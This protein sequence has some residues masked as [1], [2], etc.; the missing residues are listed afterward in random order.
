M[1][2]SRPQVKAMDVTG[3]EVVRLHG[4]DDRKMFDYC[5]PVFIGIFLFVF[6]FITSG[7]LLVTEHTGGTM[8]RFLTT[9]I[10]GV[11]VLAGYAGAFG[12]LSLV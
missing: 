2:S 3:V 6:T 11:Q 7:M 1:A 12:A 5:G 10:N 9:P 8:T 4:S